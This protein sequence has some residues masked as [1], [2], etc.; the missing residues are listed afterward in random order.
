[1]DAHIVG[2]KGL[3]GKKLKLSEFHGP[4]VHSVNYK[5]WHIINKNH[6]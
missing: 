1:M 3:E 2:R 6:I 5:V 4:K